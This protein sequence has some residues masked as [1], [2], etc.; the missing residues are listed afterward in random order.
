MGHMAREGYRWFRERWRPSEAQ[1]RVL[2]ELAA[3]RT[4]AEIAV[5]L[6]LSAGTVKWHI[7]QMLGETGCADRDALGRWWRERRAR[8]PLAVPLLGFVGRAA[9]ALAAI[10]F[11]AVLLV[12][13]GPVAARLLD[14]A[15]GA[16]LRGGETPPEPLPQAT[17]TVAPTPLFTASPRGPAAL[18]LFQEMVA[19]LNAGDAEAVLGM[20]VEEATMPGAPCVLGCRNPAAGAGTGVERSFGISCAVWHGY[21]GVCYGAPARAFQVHGQ[22]ANGVE[23]VILHLVPADG[24][25]PEYDAVGEIAWSSAAMRAAGERPF[26]SNFGVRLKDELIWVNRTDLPQDYVAEPAA[27]QQQEAATDRRPA[28]GR[29]ALALAVGLAGVVLVLLGGVAL[30]LVRRLRRRTPPVPRERR[31]R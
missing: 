17:P 10:A 20:Y 25:T 15:R 24:N 2:D 4:N 7:S 26:R 13:A 12:A 5:R 9:A 21:G 14:A 11:A 8:P 30:D 16:A 19:A 29:I 3:G 27:P 6:G 1:Q 18:A 22:I 23:I 31:V 28:D